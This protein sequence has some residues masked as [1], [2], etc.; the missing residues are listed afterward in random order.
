MRQVL[1][2]QDSGQPRSY[3]EVGS[4]KQWTSQEMKVE[5][6]LEWRN[7]VEMM[8][9]PEE[10]SIHHKSQPPLSLLPPVYSSSKRSCLLN[11]S[12]FYLRKGSGVPL[13]FA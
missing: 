13:P 3:V 9:A 5:E 10:I 12:T 1:R 11:T 6:K 7:V 4:P 2:R 8:L